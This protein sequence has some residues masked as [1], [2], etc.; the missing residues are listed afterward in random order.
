MSSFQISHTLKAGVLMT[1]IISLSWLYILNVW[2]K[3]IFQFQDLVKR[4]RS[5]NKLST[6]KRSFASNAYNRIP[7]IKS[8]K[9]FQLRQTCAIEVS[10]LAKR[11]KFVSKWEL[12]L[13][14]AKILRDSWTNTSLGNDSIFLYKHFLYYNYKTHIFLK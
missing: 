14:I 1:F 12:R 4:V 5:S 7:S 11:R 6:P 10:C 2:K 9:E 3:S 8:S 13:V